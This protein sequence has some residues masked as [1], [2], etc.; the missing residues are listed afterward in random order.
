MIL[1]F[2]KLGQYGRL[3]NNFFQIAGVLGLAEKYNA[4]A[5]FPAWKYEQYF[6]D[7]IPHGEMQKNQV[8]EKHFHYHDWE[9]K[10]SCD[11]LGYLQSEKYFPKKNPF[12]FKPDFLQRTKEK[13]P[14]E[15]WDK[16]TILFQIRRGDYVQNPFYYQISIS[17]YIDALITHFPN[18][19][20]YNIIFFSDEL[21]YAHIHFDCLPN[22]YFTDGLSDIE[23]MA[24]GSLC[25]HFIIANSSFGWWQ[26]WLGEKPHSKIIHCGHLHSGQLQEKSEP[27]DYYPERWTRHQKDS[28]KLDLRDITF[29]I[30]VYHDHHDRKQ[31]LDLSVCILQKHFETNI[32]IGEQGGSKFEYMGKYCQ[33]MKFDLPNFHRTKMLN[34]MAMASNTPYLAN[35]D[36][37][38]IIPPMQIYLAMLKLREG[39]DMVFP[40]DGRF[41]RLPRQQWFKPIEKLLDIG[42]IGDTEPKGKRGRPVP[43]SSVG[44]AVF[45]NKESFIDGGMEN[46]YMISFGPEDCERNDRFTKL[47]FK[48]DRIGTD[49]NGNCGKGLGGCLYHIDHWCGPDSSTQNPYFKANHVELEK[50]RKM[51]REELRLYV[52]T[53]PWRHQYTEAYY[54]RISFGAIRSAEEIYKHFPDYMNMKIIDIG[55]GVGEFSCGNPNY[56]GVDYNIPKKALLIPEENYINCDLEKDTVTGRYDL[57]ICLEVA[58]HISEERADVLI[59]MLCSLSDKVL[60]SAAIPDQG[61]TGHCNEQWQ[62]WWEAK[63]KDNGFGASLKQPDILENPNIE[64]WYKQNIVLYEKG[65]KGEVVDYVLP[66]YYEQIVKHLKQLAQTG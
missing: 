3:G 49:E 20:D 42:A 45:F 16:E 52:D 50:G 7:P 35:W 60:F 24:I 41:A 9:L 2:S 25:D 10:G 53:F 37:D 32:I 38:V 51:T 40:Y 44:G 17:Y 26:T 34:D 55:C 1:S 48:K 36:C 11:I 57:C 23:Q 65:G 30:P 15:V 13:L 33:Y 18:W 66:D 59:K 22:A 4:E 64:L 19:Q 56:W 29:T 5:S 43:E 46:E 47:G 62:T 54:K 21:S 8:K 14:P 28:Y 27:K 6:I 31:N 61:G 58:E 63:F 39:T 12:V